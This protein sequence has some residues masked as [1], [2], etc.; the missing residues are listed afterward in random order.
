[1]IK[2]SF[3]FGLAVLV[4]MSGCMTTNYSQKKLQAPLEGE[5]K[6]IGSKAVLSFKDEKISGSDGCNRFSGSYES[7]LDE[8]KI[9]K[10]L[11]LTMMRCEDEVAEKANIFRKN[12]A[13]AIRYTNSGKILKFIN[14]DGFVLEE[15]KSV[16]TSFDSGKYIVQ[17]IGNEKKASA[18]V[19]YGISIFIE[20]KDDGKMSGFTGCN[21]FNSTYLLNENNITI[22]KIAATR[23][24]C[25]IDNMK[26]EKDFIEA[27]KNGAKVSHK[28]GKWEL[29]NALGILL[30]E[31]IKE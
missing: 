23:K 15:F 21:R 26:A 2:K 14:S 22:S 28:D 6:S 29:R 20:L 25:P 11:A 24:M 27:M 31:M 3:Y 5:W 17:S 16:S 8:L 1:M 13:E 9:D 10:N 7:N 18:A 30:M 4:F 12:L 19:K